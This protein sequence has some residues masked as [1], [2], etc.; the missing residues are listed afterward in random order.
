MRK[1]LT[2]IIILLA[3]PTAF[4]LGLLI[5]IDVMRSEADWYRNAATRTI[6]VYGD[7][8]E[9]AS[10]EINLLLDI[11]QGLI[12]PKEGEK[13]LVELHEQMVEHNKAQEALIKE[14]EAK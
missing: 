7:T 9:T 1:T 13:K 14:L 10:L 2:R 6:Q 8:L 3:I 4:M 5:G 11:N 12:E